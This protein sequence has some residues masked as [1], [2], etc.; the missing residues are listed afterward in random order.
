MFWLRNKKSNC[1]LHTLIWRPEDLQ[2]Y[3]GVDSDIGMKKGLHV[4]KKN[5]APTYNPVAG[6]KRV[7]R[8]STGVSTEY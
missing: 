1:L 7:Q 2:V 8:K 5:D 3:V 6:M 4:N